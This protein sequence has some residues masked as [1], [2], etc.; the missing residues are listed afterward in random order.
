MWSGRKTRFGFALY[1]VLLGVTIFVVGVLALGRS[2]QNCINAS[3]LA[4]EENRIRQILSDRMAE[5]QA[6]PG[7]PD[8]AKEFTVATLYGEVKLV[9]KTIPAELEEE[10][11]TELTGVQQVSLT[12]EWTRGG[13]AQ[14]RSIEF[15]VYRAG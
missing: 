9:Q 7:A 8:A 2:V 6:T 10:D 12:V 15:Y 3:T 11:G 13:V 1:E 4:A 14:T 5:I